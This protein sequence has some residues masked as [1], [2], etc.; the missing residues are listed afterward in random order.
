MTKSMPLPWQNPAPAKPARERLT[1]E[2]IVDAAYAV[3]DRDGFDKLSM[4]AV[5]QDLGVAVSSLYAHVANK[6][7]LLHHMW[8]RSFEDQDIPEPTDDP[9][10]WVERLRQWAYGLRDSLRS[11]R[12]MA[13]VSMGQ[14]PFHPASMPYMERMMVFLRSGG[15]PENLIIGA[16]DYLSTF[17]EGFVYQ[18][19]VWEERLRRLSDEDR[20]RVDAGMREYFAGLDP[21][22]YPNM[23]SLGAKMAEISDQGLRYKGG[24][25]LIVDGLAAHMKRG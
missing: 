18:E 2:A 12:D 15:L 9:D 19:Q 24:V 4:R 17:A 13:R 23:S 11:H 6:E 20:E 21:H 3:L 14:N 8:V 22:E 25:D 5:A 16:G 7:E 10:E 1:V